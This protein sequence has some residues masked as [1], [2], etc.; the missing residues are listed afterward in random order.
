MAK[1]DTRSHAHLIHMFGYKKH[2]RY[3]LEMA[4]GLILAKRHKTQ[5]S[6][7]Y[8]SSMKAFGRRNV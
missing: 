3:P 7:P 2:D 6:P 1:A 4:F 8:G 5:I